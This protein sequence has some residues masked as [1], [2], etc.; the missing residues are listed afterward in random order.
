MSSVNL[1]L[2]VGILNR[3]KLGPLKV[4]NSF[5]ACAV[6]GSNGSG[7]R[8]YSLCRKWHFGFHFLWR[9]TLLSL[10]RGKWGLV[11]SQLDIPEFVDPSWEAFPF[12]SRG[13]TLGL[14]KVG[15]SMRRGWK[16]NSRWYVKY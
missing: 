7:T 11:L 15:E 10:D 9:D 13:Q 12:L 1:G 14:R 5:V 2:E 4:G 8:I 6:Y 16:L 3:T